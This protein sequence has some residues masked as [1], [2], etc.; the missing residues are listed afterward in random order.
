MIAIQE[1]VFGV[2]G[3]GSIVYF[4]ILLPSIQDIVGLLCRHFQC[5]SRNRNNIF[6]SFST[7]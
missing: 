5:V 7:Y 3:R 1:V 6:L 4:C 2:F